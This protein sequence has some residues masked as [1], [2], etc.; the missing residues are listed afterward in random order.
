MCTV[1]IRVPDDDVTPCY[2]L[3]VRDEDPDRPW[4]RLG[5]WWADHPSVVGVQDQL[6]G[7]AWLA[8]DPASGRLAVLLNR[9]GTPDLP[10][11]LITSRGGLVLNSVTG[12]ELP[13]PITTLGFNLVEVAGRD[14]RVTM[15]DGHSL[16]SV[17]LPPGTH[18]IA[19]DDVNDQATARV[20]AWRDAFAAAPTDGEPWW[21]AWLDVLERTTDTPPTDDTAIIRDNRTHGFPTLSLLVSVASVCEQDVWVRDAEL[22]RPGI[23]N[24]LTFV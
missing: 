5:Q 4:R 8:A 14:A 10:G 15:W 9:L 16:R 3:A 21:E 6:A 23:W 1:V 11:E 18:M 12:R 13:D 24:P 17:H 2:V 7:G 20:R 19:H 22:R